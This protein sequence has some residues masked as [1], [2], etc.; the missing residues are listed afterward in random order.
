MK[1]ENSAPKLPMDTRARIGH[2]H[3]K[4]AE[5]DDDV[6]EWNS[7][8]ITSGRIARASRTKNLSEFTGPPDLD[9]LLQ[10]SPTE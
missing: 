2:I 3:L 1:T 4:V 6:L 9:L 5:L 7:T 8:G 10:E